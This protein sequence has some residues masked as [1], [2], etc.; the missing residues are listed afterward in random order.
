LFT[1]WF[2]PLFAELA[3]GHYWVN[4]PG[5]SF[6]KPLKLVGDENN[7]ANVVI[8]M[9]GSLEW[10]AKGGWIEGVT[11]RRPKMSTGV[12]ISLPMLNMTGEAKMD[13]INC[14]FDNDGSTGSVVTISGSGSKGCWNDIIVRNGGSNGIEMEGEVTLE[15]KK[16]S[17]CQT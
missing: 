2:H 5:L 3:D 9:S 16:V 6:D 7:A 17:C 11:F 13:M 1:S 15:L 10:K 12:P 4:E 14:V 8:E